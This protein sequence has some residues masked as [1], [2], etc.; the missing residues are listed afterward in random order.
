MTKIIDSTNLGYL[1]SKIKAAFWPKTDVVQI[2]LDDTPTANSNNLVKSGGVKSALDAKQNTLVSGTSIKTINN[3]SLLGSGNISISGGSGG[4]ANVIEAITFNGNSVPVSS[5]NASIMV[6]IPIADVDSTSTATAFTA[7]VPGITA[8]QDGVCCY[9]KNTVIAS[10]AGCTLNINNLGAKPIYV[11]TAA[12]TAATTQFAK[13]YTF[14]FIYNANRISGGCWDIWQLYNTNTTYSA[15]TTS[16][17]QAGTATTARTITAAVL[18]ENYNI[19]NGT[20]NIAGNSI[21]PLVDE[22]VYIACHLVISANSNTTMSDGRIRWSLIEDSNFPEFNY[23]EF[24]TAKSNGKIIMCAVKSGTTDEFYL[25]FY[26]TDATEI[27]FSIMSGVEVHLDIDNE[28]HLI[29]QAYLYLT[30]F[31]GTYNSLVGKPT[32]PN[33]TTI[34]ASDGGLASNVQGVLGVSRIG[35]YDGAV[36]ALGSSNADGSED[37]V[38]ATTDKIVVIEC[39]N[40]QAMDLDDVTRQDIFL[41]TNCTYTY[42]NDLISQGYRPIIRLPIDSGAYSYDFVYS[43]KEEGA[44]LYFHHA[45]YNKLYV[46]TVELDNSKFYYSSSY[47]ASE[48]DPIFSASAAAEITSSD[49]TNWNSKT[50]NTGTITG[51]TMNGTSK[52]TSGVVNLGTVL[53]A[54]QDISGKASLSGAAFTGAVTG[55]SSGNAAQFRNITISSSEPTS[56]QGSN[57]DIWIVI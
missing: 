37:Y 42:L 7:T 36:Y 26:Y 6:S 40:S 55:T 41:P 52:G 16:A 11:T 15:M 22:S 44:T 49:I 54:H 14:L 27:M 28:D 50:S 17:I 25:P 5:K 21:T 43:H 8:L 23:T 29:T 13:N 38:L 35:G 39:Q 18:A 30:Y 53:T 48:T 47:L 57:G 33:V 1:I 12:A 20:I 9:L 4:E 56:S 46:I 51:I 45:E 31:N 34:L 24:N 3:E 19:T 2:G 32:I 10:A